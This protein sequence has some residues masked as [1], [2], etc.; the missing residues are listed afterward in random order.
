MAKQII[1][2]DEA[3]KKM[4]SGVEKLA[5]AVTTTLGPKGRNVALDRSWGAPNVIMPYLFPYAYLQMILFL[6]RVLDCSF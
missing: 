4:L 3:R 6:R 2:G 1:Y 5:A